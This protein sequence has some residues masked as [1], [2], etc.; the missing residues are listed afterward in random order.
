MAG[1]MLAVVA[2][3]AIAIAIAVGIVV[4]A[5]GDAGAVPAGRHVHEEPGAPGGQRPPPHR[6]VRHHHHHHHHHK[7]HRRLPECPPVSGASVKVTQPAGKSCDPPPP[8]LPES[9][10]PVALPLAGVAVAGG[11][12]L[13]VRRRRASGRR[14]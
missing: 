2:L 11:F 13:V 14:S 3:V 4:F 8:M 10:V 1:R 12:F 9:S 5:G 7:R 6:T